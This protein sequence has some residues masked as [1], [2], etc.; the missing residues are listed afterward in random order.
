MDLRARSLAGSRHLTSVH[1]TPSSASEP[2]SWAGP[3]PP[4][5]ADA[6]CGTHACRAQLPHG[7]PHRGGSALASSGGSQRPDAVRLLGEA[8]F[9]RRKG[10]GGERC[11]DRL[12][13]SGQGRP[14]PAPQGVR[15]RPRALTASA[16]LAAFGREA[17]RM[18]SL[19]SPFPARLPERGRRPH[20]GRRSVPCRTLSWPFRTCPPRGAECAPR[21]SGVGPPGSGFRT[22]RLAWAGPPRPS[23]P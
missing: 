4:G 16:D 15:G 5:K 11:R 21:H 18:R 22:P 6:E 9:G 17:G 20:P 12:R 13:S 1:L 19:P 7:H 3:S 10:R 14:R 23:V 8:S 2:Q